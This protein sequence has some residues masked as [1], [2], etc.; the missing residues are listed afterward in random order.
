MTPTLELELQFGD[1]PQAA[2][3]RKLLSRAKVRKWM[4][5]ALSGR[6]SFRCASSMPG[7]ARR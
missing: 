6:A 1:F 3:H 4:E 7:K 5:M 2:A